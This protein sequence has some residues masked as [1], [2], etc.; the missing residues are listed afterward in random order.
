MDVEEPQEPHAA[1]L[2]SQL[3]SVVMLAFD[4]TMLAC[5]E[6]NAELT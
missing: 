6:P 3:E 5:N 2:N 1:L 4:V